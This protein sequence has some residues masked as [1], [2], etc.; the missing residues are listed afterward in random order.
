MIIIFRG[1]AATGKTTLAK[2]CHDKM[3]ISVISKDTVFDDLLLKG[4]SWDDANRITYDTLAEKIQAAHD[5][6]EDL[7]V[8]I[9]L[10]HTPYYRN[11]LSMMKLKHVK[12]FL[13]MCDD[14][15]WKERMVKRIQNPQGPNQTFKSV[16]EA[17]EHYSKYHIVPISGEVCL[18]GSR[19]LEELMSLVL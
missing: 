15:I 18:E 6:G 7:I 13:F 10:S 19:P 3:G 12:H 11:F 5:A 1:K 9:G 8:D 4:I 14:H 17:K 16:S 2:A